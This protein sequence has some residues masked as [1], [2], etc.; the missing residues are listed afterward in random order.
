VLEGTAGAALDQGTIHQ[1]AITYAGSP[2]LAISLHP[3]VMPSGVRH[4][5]VGL[6]ANPDPE[7]E[8]ET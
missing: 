8:G 5:E 1:Y 7:E 3:A 2:G 6:G 4:S